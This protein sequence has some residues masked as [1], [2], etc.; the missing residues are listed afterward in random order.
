MSYTTVKALWP[1]E[2]HENLE[3]LRNSWG[4][5]PVIWGEMA[6]R[7]LGVGRFGW[8]LKIDELWP[9]YRRQDI[10]AAMRAVLMM[11]FDRAYV[12]KKDYAR[13]AADI[14][15]FLRLAPQPADRANHWPRLAEIFRGD[16][17]IPAIGLVCTSVGEDLFDGK[18]DE[19][20]EDYGPT[21]W[22]ACWSIYD[23]DVW[24]VTQ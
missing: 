17:N 16:P 6:E 24:K 21:D 10:P 20:R 13:A 2:K 5:A 3:E 8:S 7:Y 19:E 23:D 11:T 18:W 14:E 12:E 1:G 9:L 4:S 22:S 15:E